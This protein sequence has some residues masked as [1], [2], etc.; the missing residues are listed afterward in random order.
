MLNIDEDKYY[1][2]P[3]FFGGHPLRAKASMGD[4]EG[5]TLRF[6]S[7]ASFLKRFLPE[8]FALE[9]PELRFGYY[10]CRKVSWLQGQSLSIFMVSIPVAYVGSD[11]GMTGILP[12]ALWHN[13]VYSILSV[14]EEAGMPALYGEIG[15]K[16]TG[17]ANLLVTAGFADAPFAE[18]EFQEVA[19][20]SEM[21]V[22]KLNM[23]MPSR[24]F[25][26]RYIP[27][28]GAP[29]AALSHATMMPCHVTAVSGW[30]GDGKIAWHKESFVRYPHQEHVLE[31]L[32]RIP[33]EDRPSGVSF[34]CQLHLMPELARPLP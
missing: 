10:E 15:S 5:V 9:M 14:R 34:A 32:A 16:R 2:M 26:W 29:G 31:A 8:G 25:G 18:Q 23:W 17:N 1:S 13:N 20:L 30:S 27:N 6:R 4:C 7:E 33:H 11:E 22:D 12:L 19:P 28:L 21:D 3:V 24:Q